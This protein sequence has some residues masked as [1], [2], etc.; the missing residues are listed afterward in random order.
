MAILYNKFDVLRKVVGIMTTIFFVDPI[1]EAEAATAF[2][3][4]VHSQI[5]VKLTERMT[6]VSYSYS[7]EGIFPWLKL[8]AERFEMVLW[9]LGYKPGKSGGSS[10]ALNF[11][12]QEAPE[13]SPYES[14]DVSD[15][16]WFEEWPNTV[17]FCNIDLDAEDPESLNLMQGQSRPYSKGFYNKGRKGSKGGGKY[18]PKGAGPQK[19]GVGVGFNAYDGYTDPYPERFN[20]LGASAPGDT[21][22]SQTGGATSGM[23]NRG[24]A[25]GSGTSGSAIQDS[26]SVK[27]Q[28]MLTNFQ[29]GNCL[30]CGSSDHKVSQCPKPKDQDL[31]TK[32][33]HL[34]TGRGKRTGRTFALIRD[35]TDALEPPCESQAAE[36]ADLQVAATVHDNTDEPAEN[37]TPVFL[38]EDLARFEL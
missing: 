7:T 8:E 18:T 13:Y 2:M 9:P 14:A 29:T 4:A 21:G 32:F 12:S 35:I 28:E 30:N 11:L 31:L 22:R 38:A 36:T 5:Y 17:P 20:N 16:S 15:D 25:S 23:G 26:I 19:G 34:V 24:S 37:A 10:T 6:D 27:I 1:T 33:L 3:Q